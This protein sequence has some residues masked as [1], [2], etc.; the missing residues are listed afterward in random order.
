MDLAWRRKEPLV[1][2]IGED[3]TAPP[4]DPVD[5][6]RQARSD[7]HHAPTERRSV[8]CFDDQ[9]SVVA[10]QRVVHQAKA[11]AFATSGEGPLDLMHDP[12]VT[13]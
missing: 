8:V 7:R 6:P 11:R 9:M 12:N 10:L 5:G 1:I 2:T 13:E 3:R 4:C